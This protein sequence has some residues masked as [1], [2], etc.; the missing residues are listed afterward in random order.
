MP[1]FELDLGILRNFELDL[2][3]AYA[4]EGPDNGP[5]SFDHSTP[6]SLWTSLKVGIYDR[7]DDDAQS[8]WAIGVQL[9]PKL[10]VASGSHGVGVES[11]L[12]VG[13]MTPVFRTVLNFGAF[14]DPS[15]DPTSGRPIGIESGIDLEVH[16]DGARDRFFLTGELSTVHFVS[17]D[18]DQLLVT[19]GF[20]W[21]VTPSI[22]LSLV[23]LWGLLVGSDR[24]GVLFGFSPKLRVFG[25]G[26]AA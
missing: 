22:D 3:G 1:D 15:P 24:Y 7:H 17:S 14:V 10:P 6:D 8:G 11:L 2:D 18:P 13:G 26:S 4:V 21:S 12:L 5:F 9:G 16:V 20:T 25:V 23:G 19:G